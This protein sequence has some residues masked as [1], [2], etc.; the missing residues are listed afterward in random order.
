MGLTAE[1]LC[2]VLD[3]DPGMG[4]FRWIR[5]PTAT[6]NVAVGA[7]AG[8]MDADGY[9]T[10][11]LD[12]VRHRAHR[13]AWLYMHGEWPPSE[14]IDHVNG[15][16][17][18]NR[19][20]NLREARRSENVQNVGAARKDSKSGLAGV[21]ERDGRWRARIRAGGERLTLGYF[22]SPEEAHAAYRAAKLQLHPFWAGGHA[23]PR[24]A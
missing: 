21:N 12:G 6:C 15:N 4:T 13:L 5:R 11:Q 24:E 23:P 22:D 14:D 1:R 19:I 8:T 9:R 10:I 18:D 3:Y 20:A 17:A 2:E 16:R 7:E